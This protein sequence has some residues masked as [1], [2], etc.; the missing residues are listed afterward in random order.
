MPGKLANTK[1]NFYNCPE[2]PLEISHIC[3]IRKLQVNGRNVFTLKP[4]GSNTIKSVLYFHGG[5]YVQ[6]F[7]IF[8]WRFLADL[9]QKANCEVIAPDYPLAPS[10]T[11]ND[12][13]AML[14]GLYRQLIE[15]MDPGNLVLMGDSAGGGMA[16]SLAQKMKLEQVS[17]PG[18]IILL[19][20]WLD[21][22]LSNP[23]IKAIEAIDPFLSKKKLQQDGLSYAGNTSLENYLL[24]PIN[25][26]LE[27]L[28]KISIFVGSNEILVA[29]ARKLKSI[30]ASKGI[31]CNY[32][33]YAGM[34]H[35]WMLLNF[36][37]SKRARQQIADLITM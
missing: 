27:G 8:H 16:L 30:A 11:F 18:K 5:A 13:F 4:K 22:T 3:D 12:A 14:S 6:N 10:Y 35:A 26:P 23:D 7:L 28:G 20:P 37:E 33:E 34:V 19:S 31:E 17:Q 2:P 36:S 1:L 32:Y 21:I 24:S 9:S 29:D 15:G 25:G